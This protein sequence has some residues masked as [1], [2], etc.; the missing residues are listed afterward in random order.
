MEV[1]QSG[2]ES[3]WRVWLP[4]VPACFCRQAQQKLCRHGSSRGLIRTLPHSEQP[5]RHRTQHVLQRLSRDRVYHFT[6]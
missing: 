4:S 6:E 1:L 3:A 2:Q 5:A